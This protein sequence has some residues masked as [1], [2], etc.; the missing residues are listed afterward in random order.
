MTLGLR[1]LP[2]VELVPR[3]STGLLIIRVWLEPSSSKPL[4][5]RVRFTN[6][7]A[8]G[9]QQQQ[10]FADSED[11]SALVQRWLDDISMQ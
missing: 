8:L 3:D 2:Y 9:F 4:R 5:A 6:D 7:V 10:I 11:V 1:P